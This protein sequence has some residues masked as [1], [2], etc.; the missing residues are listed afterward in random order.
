MTVRSGA[1]GVL[2]SVEGLQLQLPWG[3]GTLSLQSLESSLEAPVL[4]SCS[5]HLHH[6]P[7]LMGLQ[8]PFPVHGLFFGMLVAASQLVK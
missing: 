8:T 5:P 4:F 1:S 2:G 6:L 3:K 7:R